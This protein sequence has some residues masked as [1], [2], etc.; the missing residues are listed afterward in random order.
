MQRL[1]NQENEL[2]NREAEMRTRV[3][4]SDTQLKQQRAGQSLLLLLHTSSPTIASMRPVAA[5]LEAKKQQ[6]ER[7]KSEL[8]K[9]ISFYESRLG[10]T[11]E[12]VG[13][14]PAALALHPVKLMVRVCCRRQVASGVP[15]Y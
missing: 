9:G 4:A 11:F 10:L 1:V 5:G 2:P 8:E 14:S 6:T 7:R 13:G 12:R 15:P 3:T